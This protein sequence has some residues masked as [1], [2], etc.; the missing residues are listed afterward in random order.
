MAIKE[1]EARLTE[2]QGV[3]HI[4][5]WEWKPKTNELYWSDENYRIFGLPQEIK[6]SLDAFF[7]TV[8]PDDLEFVKKNIDDALNTMKPYNIVLRII[9]PDGSQGYVHAMAEVDFDIEGNPFR[10]YG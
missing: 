7:I 1:S 5:N 8:H 2:A 3:A 4:G 9:K 6:P 10:M